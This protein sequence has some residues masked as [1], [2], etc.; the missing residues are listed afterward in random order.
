VGKAFIMM[1]VNTMG[2]LLLLLLL[3]LLMWQL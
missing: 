3:L 2:G 1:A